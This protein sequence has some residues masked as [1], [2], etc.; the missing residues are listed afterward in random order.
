M[1]IVIA[2]SAFRDRVWKTFTLAP[3]WT[4]MLT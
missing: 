2:G 3:E 1:P 4:S